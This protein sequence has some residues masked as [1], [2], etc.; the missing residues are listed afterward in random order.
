MKKAFALMLLLAGI[1]SLQAQL[2]QYQ[3]IRLGN[4]SGPNEPSIWINP[5]NPSQIM[6]GSNLNFWYYSQDGGYNWSSGILTE[7]TLGV[8]GD[9]VIITD[10]LG[11]FYYFHLSNP[12]NGSWIDR[13]VCQKFNKSTNTWSAGTYMGLNGN[14]AQDKHW[15]VVDPA[16][17]TIHVTWTQFDTY[18]SSNPDCQSNIR[19]SKSVDAGQ[20]WSNA[21]TINQVPGDCIDSDNTVEGAVPAV[22]PNGEVY[23]SWSGPQGIVFDR[24]L[25]G[26][27]TWLGNDIFVSNQP[28]GWDISIPGIYRCNGMPVTVCDLSN[29]PRQG[30]IY[31][32]WADQRN[33]SND[34]DVW[35][36]RS[37]DGGNTWTAPIR[38]ND[39]QPGKHQ[40][41]T[42]MTIDQSTGYLYF[43]FYDRRNHSNNATDVYMAVS[44][45]GG[46]TFT[47]FKV[48]ESP[49]TPSG[50]QF[51]G[52]YNNIAAVNG[53]VRPIWTRRES[54]GSLAI[55]TAIVD[56]T[57]FLPESD[58]GML[59]LEP[60]SPN[61]FNQYTICSFRITKPGKVLLSMVDARGNEV[62]RLRDEF[63]QPGKYEVVFDNV[64]HNLS[65]GVYFFSLKSAQ[66]E[67]KQKV[68]LTY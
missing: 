35:L 50:G 11:D 26:G 24:S 8:W 25:D 37:T 27:Q 1:T 21:I 66:V 53:Q 29:G 22:G 9:P 7:P 61:P 68:I 44:Y 6:A 17:N 34:T 63:M 60:T 46:E 33:G 32:N 45:D 20:T 5:K 65:P 57:T 23:V 2:T 19:Y 30:T 49:F 13:I 40:F 52:D 64:A 36:T 67:K 31:I 55:Y 38:V 41:F 15:A 43:V 54:N 62:A 10:T 51:F 3:N 42:W 58:E 12:V 28:G 48:S 56:M 59:H 16:N 39:D 14:K 47:N 18:G 4:F